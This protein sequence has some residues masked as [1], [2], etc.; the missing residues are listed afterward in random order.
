[1]ENLNNFF[2]TIPRGISS[3]PSLKVAYFRR[4][5]AQFENFK[6]LPNTYLSRYFSIF[7]VLKLQSNF[8]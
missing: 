7:D 1:M 5:F 2:S 3:R 6:S 4:I 8:L